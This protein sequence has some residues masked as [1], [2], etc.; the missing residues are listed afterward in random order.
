[1]TELSFTESRRLQLGIEESGVTGFIIHMKPCNLSATPCVTRWKITALPNGLPDG[2][3]GIGF[4][5]RNV[6]LLEVRYGKPGSWQIEW[7]E[8]RFQ[9]ISYR[10]M[11]IQ[12]K[13]NQAG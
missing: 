4:P 7:A 5:R 13:Q 11:D 9:D 1:M 8:S 6:E 10:G 12:E 2:M 3:P